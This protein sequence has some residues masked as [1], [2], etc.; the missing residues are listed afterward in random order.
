[1][2][3]GTGN[4]FWNF[5]GTSCIRRLHRHDIFRFGM[6][7]QYLRVVRLHSML[8]TSFLVSSVQ[9]VERSSLATNGKSALVIVVSE[10]KVQLSNEHLGLVHDELFSSAGRLQGVPCMAL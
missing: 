3:P 4:S 10:S 8:L 1:M 6:F 9:P 2:K 7:R 5:F